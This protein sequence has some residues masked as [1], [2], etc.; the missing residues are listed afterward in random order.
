MGVMQ[1]NDVDAL[2]SHERA[3]LWVRYPPSTPGLFDPGVG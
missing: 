1:H 2:R 3:R